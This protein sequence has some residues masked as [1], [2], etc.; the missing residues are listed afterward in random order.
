MKLGFVSAILADYDFEQV[1]DFAAKEKFD[2]VEVACWPVGKAERRYAG[3]THID[4]GALNAAQAEKINSLLREKGVS[5]S[6]LAYYPNPLDSDLEQ[7]AVALDHLKKVI[8]AAN[9]LGVG[10]MNTFLGKDPAKTITENFA[11]F[12]KVWPEII[13]YAESE[14][15]C[16][17]IE[18]C[19][20][21]FRDE[22]PGGK[23][24]AASPKVWREMFAEIDSPNF[25]LNYDPS[26]LVW[27]RMD[28]IKPIYEF[29]NKLFHFHIKD[30][31]FY[32]DK[33]DD[34]GIFA[35]PLEY[36][37]PKLPGLGDIDWGRTI[38]ALTD[39]G[40]KGPAVIEV[41]DRAFEDTLE[42]RLDSIRLSRDFCRN[43]IR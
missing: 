9:V 30:A 16:I 40:Y 31:K 39:I 5:L 11:E 33:Y 43:Y 8:H 42:D 25:G 36:Q 14:N 35:A 23:N 20:M 19:P 6:A 4:V 2:C 32:Q 21:Y 15:V 37:A 10:Q 17:G 18:N 28:Y 12:K 41:E 26:H 3:V 13:K 34:V 29:R 1:I 7:R 38:S 24:L 22:W 27:Q